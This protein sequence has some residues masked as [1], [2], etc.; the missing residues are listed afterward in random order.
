MHLVKSAFLKK[1]LI[2]NKMFVWKTSG[3]LFWFLFFACLLKDTNLANFVEIIFLGADYGVLW[4]VFEPV[5][6]CKGG[7]RCGD[8]PLRNSHD[9]E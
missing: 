1:H 3:C 6:L 4:E 7:R 8:V 9:A 5:V 2:P